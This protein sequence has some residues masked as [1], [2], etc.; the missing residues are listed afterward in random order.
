MPTGID[1]VTTAAM[2]TAMHGG[3]AITFAT[4][5]KL[6]FLTVVRTADNTADTEWATSA[7]YVAGTGFSGLTFAAAVAGAPS[8]Q[9]SNIAAS[10]TNAPAGTWA[11]CVEVDSSGTPKKLFYGSFTGGSKTVNLGDTCTVGSGS[12]VDSLG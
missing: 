11:G 9:A 7:G 8:T 2:L 5:E 10:I 6:L 4:P 3:T 12:L 1:S